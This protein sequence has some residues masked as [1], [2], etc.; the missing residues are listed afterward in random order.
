[1]L[2]VLL[3][4]RGTGRVVIARIM[5]ILCS[6]CFV[7]IGVCVVVQMESWVRLAHG[8]HQSYCSIQFVLDDSESVCV[9]FAVSFV[10]RVRIVGLGLA[11]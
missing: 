7:I 9:V 8:L 2:L 5:D 6:V 3:F 4:A 1:L 10:M 11:A